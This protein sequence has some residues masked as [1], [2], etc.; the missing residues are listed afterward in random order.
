LLAEHFPETTRK[1]HKMASSFPSKRRTGHQ[2]NAD[3][4]TAG[5]AS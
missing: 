3:V 1:V 2:D 4:V 5:S